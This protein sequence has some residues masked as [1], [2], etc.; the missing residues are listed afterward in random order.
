MSDII[1]NETLHAISS[2]NGR[3]FTLRKP[4]APWK[5]GTF[6]NQSWVSESRPVKGY[7]TNGRM[8]VNIRFDDNCRNGHNTFAITADV[9]TAES[10][11]MRDIAAGGCLHEEI[12][13][14][15]PELA[16]LILW[17]LV[18]TDGPMHYIANTLYHAKQNG[19]EYAWVYC[20]GRID[21]LGIADEKE[22]LLGYLK[23]IEARKAEGQSGYRV[24]WDQK[25]AKAR[26]LDFAR[27]T[28]C[29]PEATADDLCAP[30]DAL[31]AALEARLPALLDAF[32]KDMEASGFL[33][34]CPTDEV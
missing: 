15:F 30:P 26:N 10:K 27:S 22:H 20:T 13:R 17:H 25:T 3:L 23:A 28:A 2:V 19:A 34:E 11:R 24:E 5:P 7:G 32:R 14:V 6:A 1:R 31:K 9:V 4:P 12:A 21:P 33:W 16:H 29:W 8:T 18:S